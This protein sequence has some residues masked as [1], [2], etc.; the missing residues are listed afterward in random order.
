VERCVEPFFLPLVATIREAN[1][2]RELIEIEHHSKHHGHRLNFPRRECPVRPTV[3][4]GDV[5]SVMPIPKPDL[6]TPSR[7]RAEVANVEVKAVS[8]P[9]C[10]RRGE[11][12]IAAPSIR[13]GGA[14]IGSNGYHD[15]AH[16]DQDSDD[17][18]EEFS[19]HRRPSVVTLRLA[20]G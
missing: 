1:P 3:A 17:R 18:E 2:K 7:G 13:I 10:L 12:R 9:P 4:G 5:V 19:A 14:T 6:D 8:S 11:L 16:R 15:R 20:A